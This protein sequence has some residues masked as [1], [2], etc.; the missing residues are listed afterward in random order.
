MDIEIKGIIPVGMLDWEG[1]MVTTL[2][3]GECNFRCPFCQNPDLVKYPAQLKTVPWEEIKDLLK[4]KRGWLDG[5]VITGGEPTIHLGLVTLLSKIKKM[6]YPVKLDTNGTRP[7]VL[8]QLIADSLVDYVALDVKSTWDKYGKATKAP[9][10]T[11]KVKKSVEVLLEAESQDKVEVEFR[12]TVVPRYVDKEDVLEIAQFLKDKGAREYV[13][14]Q[15]S[16]KI[17]LEPEAS[18]IKPYDKE[19]LKALKEE[20]N[21]VIPTILKGSSLREAV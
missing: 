9:G 5:V 16:S 1:R 3:V 12:T 15:F 18:E 8:S 11:E 14:Q 6:G 21:R 13:L 19:E 10:L 17:T 4:T 7:R 20:C 2:F